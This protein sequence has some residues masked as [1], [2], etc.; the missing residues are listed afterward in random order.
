MLLSFSLKLR[1]TQCCSLT[2]YVV[3]DLVPDLTQFYKQYRSIE[4]FL[5]A[6]SVPEDGTEHRQSPEERRKLD[7]LY[8]CILC[9]W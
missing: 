8:E 9:A 2:V 5:K 3:K 6:S 4:P 1:L 7:G